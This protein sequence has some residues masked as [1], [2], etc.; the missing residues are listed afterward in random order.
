MRGKSSG[1]RYETEGERKREEREE[2]ETSNWKKDSFVTLFN[3]KKREKEE[4]KQ[5]M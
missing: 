1:N 4:L 3:S 5:E 2:R